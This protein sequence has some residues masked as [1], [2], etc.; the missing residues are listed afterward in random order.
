MRKVIL[1]MIVTLDGFFAGPNGEIDWHYVDQEHNR[2]AVE[3]LRS[4][5]AL[6]FGRST[7]QV[8]LSYWPTAPSSEV[9][10]RMNSLPKIVFSRTLKHVEWKNSRL[11]GENIAEEISKMKREPGK[12]LLILGSAALVT[13]FMNLGLIDEY[14][15]LVNPIVLGGGKPLF[16]ALNQRHK[17]KLIKTKTR[18]SGV[19]ELYYQ[20]VA[21]ETTGP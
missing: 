2:H 20:P 1:S 12:D 8:M 15:I 7:Y 14:Q 4:A 18:N 5:D 16:N 17:L 21:Q 6:L 9:A 3:L 13:C 19:V 11:A 10:D